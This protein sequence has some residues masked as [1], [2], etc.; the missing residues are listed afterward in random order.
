MPADN[1]YNRVEMSEGTWVVICL[2]TPMR[3]E[4]LP[5]GF[6]YRTDSGTE[7]ALA[8]RSGFA[9]REDAAHYAASTN[10]SWRP[11]VAKLEKP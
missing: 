4:D 3:D 6:D 5:V 9:T 2:G 1:P 11:M 7:P 10:P 8:T